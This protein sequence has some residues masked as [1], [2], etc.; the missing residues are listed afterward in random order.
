MGDSRSAARVARIAEI[1][2]PIRNANVK[3]DKADVCGNSLT[4]KASRLSTFFD[5]TTLL[6]PV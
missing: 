3:H 4:A 2:T 5:G 1:G 6:Q